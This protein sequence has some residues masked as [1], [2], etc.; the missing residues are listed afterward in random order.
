MCGRVDKAC[1][2]ANVDRS[3]F[4][5]WLKADP[6]YKAAFE[7]AQERTTRMLE[8]EAFR[9]AF[10]GVDEPVFHQ[11]QECGKIRRYSD[12]LLIFLLKAQNP[13]KYREKFDH[14][15]H[16]TVSVVNFVGDVLADAAAADPEANVGTESAEP[17]AG[18]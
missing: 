4:Y 5:D 9:R 17:Q 12:T 6:D 1:Q 3:T 10:D 2:S 13:A 18:G 14:T 11:G 8:D 7:A 16:G 15:H